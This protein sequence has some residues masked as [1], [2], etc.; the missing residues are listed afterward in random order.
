MASKRRKK[1]TKNAQQEL[2]IFASLEPTTQD[3]FLPT[4]DVTSTATNPNSIPFREE[5]IENGDFMKLEFNVRS[6]EEL[7]DDGSDWEEPRSKRAKEESEESGVKSAWV[8]ETDELEVLQVSQGGVTRSVDAAERAELH[9]RA[10]GAAPAWASG[11]ACDSDD[12]DAIVLTGPAL[13]GGGTGGLPP[14]TLRYQCVGELGRGARL[15]AHHYRTQFATHT[16][17]ALVTA[18]VNKPKDG[19]SK[20]SSGAPKIPLTLY[21]VGDDEV[22]VATQ[23]PFTRHPI[24]CARLFG[25]DRS[26]VVAGH[27]VRA[28]SVCDLATAR[29]SRVPWDHDHCPQ[30]K[31]DILS[32]GPH[33]LLVHEDHQC[34]LLDT[35]GA[36]TP[37]HTF[38]SQAGVSR[39]AL[40]GDTLVSSCY[41]EGTVTVWDA[42]AGRALVSFSDEGAVHGT[43]VAASGGLIAAG[44]DSGVV[45]LYRARDVTSNKFSPLKSFKQLTQPITELCFSPNQE[46]LLFGSSLPGSNF[47]K[48]AH[49]GSNTVF[50]NF[51][52]RSD[53]LLALHHAAFS[54]H[55]GCLALATRARDGNNCVKRIRLHHYPRL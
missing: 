19:N 47:V 42:R 53:G 38:Q 45:N 7:S 11:A 55:G 14:T 50:A 52:A 23:L 37:Q 34:R 31:T 21:H 18:C 1:S 29:W 49:L 26:V 54:P 43:A 9:S 5:D 46:T 13:R 48:L 41:A 16:P 24:A 39:V 35:R 8:D 28:L 2:S 10:F 32:Y 12:D 30:R 17:H 36:W 4:L 40:D 22:R 3:A 20:P 25:G 15:G 51:P 27:H 33:C 6:D 44:S